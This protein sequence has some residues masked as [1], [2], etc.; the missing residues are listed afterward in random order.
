MP[1][2][3]LQITAEARSYAL[4]ELL[5]RAG[6]PEDLRRAWKIEAADAGLTL[7]LSPNGPTVRIEF[8]THDRELDPALVV[9]KAWPFP[10]PQGLADVVPD[11]VVPYARRESRPNEPLFLET[12]PGCF[13]CTEDLLAAT[14]LVLSRFEELDPPRRDAHGRF[15]AAASMAVRDGYLDRPIVDEYGLALESLLRAVHPAW[16]PPERTLLVKLSHDIDEIGIPFSLR[17]LAVQLFSRRSIAT[18]L[19]DLASGFAPIMPGSLRQVM[20]ICLLAEEHGLRPALYWK[21][22]DPGPCDSGYNVADRRVAEVR[23]WASERGIEMGVHPGYDTFL[24]PHAL[25]REVDRCRAAVHSERIGGRQH[26]L[27]WRPET[28]IHWEQCGLAYDS[29]VGYADRVGFRAGTCVPYS[30]W[31]WHENRRANLLEIPLII[32]DRTVTSSTYMGLSPDES[33]AMVKTLMRR[34]EA[35]GGVLTLLWH[36]NCLGRPFSSYYPGIFAALA[37]AENYGWETDIQAQ[38]NTGSAM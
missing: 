7:L 36:N 16:T 21:A 22:S 28:W 19:R 10:A 29:T 15:E 8:P 30:P 27:R 14:V 3:G 4:A 5:R 32:M 12:S 1:I 17:E 11:F 38:R 37:G 33:I 6:V 20:Q 34:C 23:S 35:V 13:R 31:L 2:G 18:G 26:Y 9:R 24:S 25:R